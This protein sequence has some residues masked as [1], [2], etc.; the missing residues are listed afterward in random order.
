VVIIAF[1]FSS[2]I[3]SK[4]S[5]PVLTNTKKNSS[6]EPIKST[7]SDSI[8]ISPVYYSQLFPDFSINNNISLETFNN[9]FFIL[10]GDDDDDDDDDEGDDDDNDGVDDEEEEINKREVS[11]E[12][13]DE[14]AT[15]ESQLISGEEVNEY[16]VKLETSDEGIVFNFNFVSDTSENETDLSFDFII[17]EIIEY[18]DTSGEG[19]Y[20]QSIDEFIQ[21]YTFEE[22]NPIQYSKL[23]ISNA[24]VHTLES[25]THDGLF[26]FKLYVSSQ[27]TLLNDTIIAPTQVK[28]DFKISNFD[29]EESNSDLA[30]KIMFETEAEYEEKEETEDEEEGRAENESE[31]LISSGNYSGFFSWNELA[32]IDGLEKTVTKSDIQNEEETHLFYL[33]YPRGNTIIHDPKIGVA[34]I[35]LKPQINDTTPPTPPTPTEPVEPVEPP[36][37][38]NFNFSANLSLS[39][40][41]PIQYILVSVVVTAITIPLILV[42]RK[43]R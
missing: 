24:T 18:I 30:L 1:S 16:T 19:I 41:S 38:S 5:N 37:F 42:A 7:F 17:S 35:L 13:D 15:I 23:N 21:K 6:S 9:S 33:N 12:V 29:F 3:V 39:E 2:T 27:F 25:S 43:R 4:G 28:I 8:T 10:N 36:I 32:L 11:V 31:I 14:E 26:F 40:I 34:N 22:F 20:N